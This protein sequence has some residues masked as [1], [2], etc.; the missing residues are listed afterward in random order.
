[1]DEINKKVNS[2]KNEKE[3]GKLMTLSEFRREVGIPLILAKKLILWG[4]V[5]AVRAYDGTLVIAEEEV[6]RIKEAFKNPRKKLRYFFRALGPG[7]VTGASDDD[8]SGIG[9]YSAVGAKFGFALLWMALWLLPMMMAVQEVC[10]RIGI[11]TNKGLSGVL[12]K[13][14][15]KKIVLGI[16]S[17]LIIANVINIGADLGAMAASLKMLIGGNFYFL[18]ISF[19]IIIILCEVFIA[20]HQYVK[21]LKW[22]TIS[23]FAYVVTGIIIKPDWSLVWENLFIPHMSFSKEY[24]FAIVAV[25]GTTISPYLFF[26]QASEEVEENKIN[27]FNHK[28]KKILHGRISQMRTD[29][30]TGMFL[31]N[32]V[33]F[34]IVVTTAQVLFSQGMTNINSAEQAAEALRPFAGPLAYLLFALGIIGTGLLAIP[35]LAGSGAYALSEIFKW[36]EGLDLKFSR[37]KGFYTIITVSVIF[38]LMLNFFHV[39]PITALF[40]AAFLNGVISLPLLIVIMVVGDDKKIMGQETN[41]RWVRF[42][43]WLSVVFVIVAVLAM[44]ILNFIPSLQF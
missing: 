41:P 7:I 32:A 35:I 25:F 3:S 28:D 8:P 30:S 36:K 5:E 14:Y 10:A 12:L 18:A 39:N 1:M 34:F 29:V 16:V 31:A 23:V 42:F 44:L 21:V 38:G 37:A 11:V 13:H 43:G 24:L 17:I 33:F 40:W 20:Y 27:G 2:C 9:T 22:L 6:C 26:W 15:R 19:A 4:E